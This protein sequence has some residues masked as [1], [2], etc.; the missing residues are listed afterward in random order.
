MNQYAIKKYAQAL[1]VIPRTLS[2]NAGLDS[3]EVLSK[4]YAAHQTEP[5]AAVDIEVGYFTLTFQSETNGFMNAQKAAVY[6]TLATKLSALQMATHA[7]LT[8]LSVDQIIMSKPAGGPKVKENT[9]WD[10]D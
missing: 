4:L 8:I 3:T 2:E 9:N 6:D 5:C 7:A 1:E 10:E